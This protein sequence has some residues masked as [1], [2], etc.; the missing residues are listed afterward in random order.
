MIIVF[1]L[2]TAVMAVVVAGKACTIRD[3]SKTL[4]LDSTTI[5]LPQPNPTSTFTP[6]PPQPNL[7]PN[8]LVGGE[9]LCLASLP[10]LSHLYCHKLAI[11]SKNSITLLMLTLHLLIPYLNFT[12]CENLNLNLNLNLKLDLNPNLYLNV[13]LYLNITLTVSCPLN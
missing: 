9:L 13:N 8:F 12:D 3:A 6:P 10:S 11:F 4:K 5:K 7:N 1:D 2:A